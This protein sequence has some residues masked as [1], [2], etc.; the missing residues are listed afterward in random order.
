ML[1]KKTFIRFEFLLQHGDTPLHVAVRYNN[2]Q[3]AKMLRKEG[4]KV[5]KVNK[6]PQA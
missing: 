1:K 2:Y 3:V 6:S 5:D 4:A